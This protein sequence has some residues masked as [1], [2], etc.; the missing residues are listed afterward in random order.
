MKV[1]LIFDYGKTTGFGHYM[2]AEAIAQAIR[3][4]TKDYSRNLTYLFWAYTPGESASH[5]NLN[6]FKHVVIDSYLMGDKFYNDVMAGGPQLIVVDDGFVHRTYTS[7]P[8]LVSPHIWHDDRYILLRKAFWNVEKKTIRKKVQNVLIMFG[9][10]EK[11][12]EYAQLTVPLLNDN[13]DVRCLTPTD[14]KTFTEEEVLK[15]MLW[16]D[17]AISGCGVTMNELACVGVPSIGVLV[18]EDQRPCGHAFMSR[19]FIKFMLRDKEELSAVPKM[20]ESDSMNY[21]KR[22]KMSKLG[23]ELVDGRGAHRFVKEILI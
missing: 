6:S 10:G 15:S 21:D 8:R 23:R 5:L 22:K 1:A 12:K 18:G 4:V 17:I 2:R 9:G 19:G 16:A 20:L 3:D 14:R 11:A 7:P 13:Y